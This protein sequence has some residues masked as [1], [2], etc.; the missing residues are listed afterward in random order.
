MAY[1]DHLVGRAVEALRKR[2]PAGRSETAYS[3]NR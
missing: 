1:A 3:N 2:G